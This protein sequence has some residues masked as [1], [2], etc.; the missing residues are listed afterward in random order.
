[1]SVKEPRTTTKGEALATLP[2]GENSTR[3]KRACQQ[4]LLAQLAGSERLTCG[5]RHISFPG[6]ERHLS[7]NVG[8]IRTGRQVP[9]SC[10]RPIRARRVQDAAGLRGRLS[11]L[12]GRTSASVLF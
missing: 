8:S 5:Y 7:A 4:E 11:R 9:P 1:M 6:S 3:A 2:V 10:F 12:A